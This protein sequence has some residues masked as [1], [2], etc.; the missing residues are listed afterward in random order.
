[1]VAGWHARTYDLIILDLQMPGMSGFEVMEAL[2]PLEPDGWLPVLV[3]T[4]QPDHKMRAFEMRR[5]RFHQQALRSGRDLTR[6]RNMLE[7]RLLHNR[8]RA[9]TPGSNRPCASAP[10]NCSASA[11]PWMPPPTPSSCSMPAA[12][13]WSTSTTALAACWAIRARDAGPS[14]SR[15]ASARR[16]LRRRAERLAAYA[17]AVGRRAP[18]LAELE[19]MRRDLI[20]VP[21]ELYWQLLQR[22]GQPSVLLGVARDISER[23]QA[24][25]RCS[26]WPTT[27]A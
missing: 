14:A 23:R 27:T 17:A 21:V 25:E 11:A 3:V 18:E 8:E 20:A 13:N 19:L 9:T 2:K 16:P 26:T 12:P 10:P 22:P 1:V 6:I 24:E 5:A 15:W 4:A 7:M